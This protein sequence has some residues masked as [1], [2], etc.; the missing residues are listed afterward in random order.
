[1]RAFALVAA[2][3]VVAIAPT[4]TAQSTELCS[5][6]VESDGKLRTEPAEA[7]FVT[8]ANPLLRLPEG[9]ANVVALVCQRP[10]LTIGDNDYLVLTELEIPL[11]V[12]SD[13]RILVL[14][15]VNGQFR[16]RVDNGVLTDDEASGL[17]AAL[18]R[19]QSLS[20]GEA[21]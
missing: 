3:A 10:T 9:H 17:Q 18:N 5:V 4:A 8:G 20:Q 12:R 13:D 15:M 21:N 14:E 1:M 19:A 2:L 7:Y 16:V 11:Y 6:M